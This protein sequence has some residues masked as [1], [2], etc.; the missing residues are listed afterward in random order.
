MMMGKGET[1][2]MRVT[3][4][5]GQMGEFQQRKAKMLAQLKDFKGG[6]GVGGGHSGKNKI[7]FLEDTLLG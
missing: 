7:I 3:R 4:V 1:G 2:K 6:L 5:Q